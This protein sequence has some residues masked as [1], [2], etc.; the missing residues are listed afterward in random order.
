MKNKDERC[1]L[2]VDCL[3]ALERWDRATVLLTDMLRGSPDQWTYI[4]QYLKCQVKR[5][6]NRRR[7]RKGAEP[8]DDEAEGED[9]SS[10]EGS[11]GGEEQGFWNDME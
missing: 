9:D 7:D 8:R 2:Q 10:L 3:I 1:S 5:C 11:E 6:E 4:Q